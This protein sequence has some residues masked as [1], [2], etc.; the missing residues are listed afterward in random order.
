MQ[1][2]YHTDGY[3]TEYYKTE[4]VLLENVSIQHLLRSK[5]YHFSKTPRA[6][7]S[8][9]TIYDCVLTQTPHCVT[10]DWA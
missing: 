3:Y 4:P 5:S 1:V 2:I 6:L 9:I 7:V 10:W 8:D